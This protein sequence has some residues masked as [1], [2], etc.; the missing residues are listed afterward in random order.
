MLGVRRVGALCGTAGLDSEWRGCSG[1]IGLLVGLEDSSPDVRI[2][3]NVI[4][5]AAMNQNT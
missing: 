3:N 5:G 1:W 2:L 4:A